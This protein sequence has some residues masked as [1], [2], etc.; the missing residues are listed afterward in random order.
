MKLIAAYLLA[1]LGGKP[2]PTAADVKNIL[3]SGILAL[4]LFLQILFTRHCF[5]ILLW[6]GIFIMIKHVLHSILFLNMTE[7][8]IFQLRSLN[9]IIYSITFKT[10]RTYD[11]Y[12]YYGHISKPFCYLVLY[13]QHGSIKCLLSWESGIYVRM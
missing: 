10:T 4:L 13:R 6:S 5:H 8:T 1:H 12:Y 7:Y 2:S 3:D 11:S 9:F